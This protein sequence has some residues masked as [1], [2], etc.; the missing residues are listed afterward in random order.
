M[1]V[2]LALVL[3]LTLTACQDSTPPPEPA[4]PASDAAAA[5]PAAGADVIVAESLA[6][7]LP[8]QVGDM[9]RTAVVAEQDGAMGLTVARAQATYGAG[10]QAVTLL[11]LDVGS[12]EGFRLMGLAAPPTGQ[13]DGW[14]VRRSES[15]TGSSVQLQVGGRYFV[16]AR[17]AG[18][19][20][21]LLDVYVRTVNLTGLP[22]GA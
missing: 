17:G 9:A 6:S 22:G 15:P 12:P 8:S 11:V 4:A 3:A 18:V 10:P 1:P 20:L 13:L 7:L 5:R 14:P 2:R 19:G 21:D 16:E